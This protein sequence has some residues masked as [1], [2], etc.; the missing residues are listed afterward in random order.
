MNKSGT[1]VIDKIKSLLIDDGI[2]TIRTMRDVMEKEMGLYLTESISEIFYKGFYTFNSK[3][4]SFT[5]TLTIYLDESYIVESAE[6]PLDKKIKV[7]SI[8]VVIS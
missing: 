6:T 3:I 7:K 5:L 2:I 4:D 1:T 8:V